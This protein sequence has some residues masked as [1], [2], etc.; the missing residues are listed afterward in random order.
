[1][2]IEA[3][4][5]KEL[6]DTINESHPETPETSQPM[7]LETSEPET[8]ALVPTEPEVIEGEFVEI[9]PAEDTTPPKQKPY[10][11]LIPFT[12]LFC[13]AFLAGTFLL[14]LLAPS[15]TVTIIPVE[16]TITTTAV[17][18]VPGR[19]L[20]PLTL[21][22]RMSVPATG[23]RHQTATSAT[24]TITLYN[25][26]LTSQTIA[27]GTILTGNDGVQI[28]TDQAAT[29]PAGNPPIY[30][31]VSVPANAF[32]AGES[33]NISA[34]DINTACCATS[35]V[36]KNTQGFTGGAS[37]RDVLVAT[38]DDINTAVTSLLVTLGQSEN[39]ALQA[40]LR[41]GEALITPS[42][43]PRVSSDHKPGDEAKHVTVTVSVTCSG[44]A[45]VARTLY[46]VATQLF[47]S[48]GTRKLGA[49][50]T[51]F[52]D[53]HITSIQATGTHSRQGQVR[54]IVQVKGAF[55]YQITKAIQQ[56]LIYLIAGKPKQ[57]ALATLLIFPG[58]A[59]AN[60]TVKGGS[61]TLPE[62]P[63]SI[64]IV[65]AYRSALLCSSSNSYK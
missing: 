57:Q 25:G 40:Q 46:R 23:N 2:N 59:G 56:K 51:L 58:I 20:L 13:L 44:I 33:G 38:R 31:Q 63:G 35:V 27:P 53:I 62:N 47:I 18:Q 6:T 54:T 22:Q 34:Y 39:A 36:A 26:L 37:A 30:G 4:E 52:G 48:D 49:H 65:V 17:I 55:V 16:Q 12:I 32:L 14:P 19:A 11:L 8:T 42:C 50:F 9:A 28:I 43:N 24:G 10:W 45:Y 1:M 41:P 21:M 64:T 29:I 60:I 15:A 61:Q 7:Q 3:L 5:E